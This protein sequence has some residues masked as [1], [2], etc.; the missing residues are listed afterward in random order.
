[1]PLSSTRSRFGAS[2]AVLKD[3]VPFSARR[4]GHPARKCFQA[5]RIAVNNELDVINETITAAFEKLNV[6]GRIAIITFHSLEDR[7]VKKSFQ[8]LCEGCTCPPDFPVCVCGKT[9]KAKLV[10][11]KPIT[12]TS[13]ELAVNTRSRSAKLRIIEKIKEG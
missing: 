7:I 6:G 2:G 9:P 4:E 1:M 12:A 3:S 11:K 5:L 10:N 8:N 13:E